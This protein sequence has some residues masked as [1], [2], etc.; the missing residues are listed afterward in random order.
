MGKRRFSRGGEFKRDLA[1]RVNS[2]RD[3]E[4]EEPERQDDER[5]AE[6]DR[7]PVRPPS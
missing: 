4:R 5:D 1:A 2:T 7:P 6:E 3:D